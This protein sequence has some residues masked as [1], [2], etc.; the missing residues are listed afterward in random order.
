MLGL[1]FIKTGLISNESGK[2]YS[3][4]FNKRLTGDYDDFLDNTKEDVLNLI[5]PAKKFISEIERLLNN[6]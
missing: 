6:K 1:H 2:F 3:T 5:T 4:I